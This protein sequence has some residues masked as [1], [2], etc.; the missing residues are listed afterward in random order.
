[1]I[2]GI[3]P[4]NAR[5]GWGIIKKEGG[6]MLHVACGCIETSKTLSEAERLFAIAEALSEI[7]KAY[8][9]SEAAVE[10]IFLFKNPKTVIGVAEA[11]G[12]VLA[13]LAKEKISVYSYT[14]LQVKQ[15]ITS[16]GKADKDQVLGM[17]MRILKLEK[18]PKPDDAA[19]ALAIALCHAAVPDVLKRIREARS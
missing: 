15:A 14:P 12:V 19:D 9:P 2:I 8:S 4:G 3:D 7:V 18:P 17:V 6:R 11:R 13:T 16:Y 5:C 1:M 10:A